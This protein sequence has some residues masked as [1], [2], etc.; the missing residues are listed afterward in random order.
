[1]DILIQAAQLLLSLSILVVLH[2]FGHF[3]PAKIFKT[4]VEKFYLFFDWKFSIF[5]KK[6]G[7]TEWGIGWLPLGGYVKISGMVDE[8][9]DTEQ[10]AQP[11]QPWEFRAKPAWQRLIIMLGGVT[12][13]LIL[14]CLIYILV[15]FTYGVEKMNPNDVTAGLSVTPMLEKYG[16]QTGDVVLKA[17][18]KVIDNAKDV[19]KE[20]MLRGARTF[21]VKHQDGKTEN[22]TLPEDIDYNLFKSGAMVP[23]NFRMKSNVVDSILPK[24]K[25][26]ANGIL[27]K[28]DIL[29]N[30]GSH[31]IEY[32][33]QTVSALYENKG[34]K[35]DITIARGND[36]L[37]KNIMVSKEGTIGFA[38]KDANY[39]LDTNKLQLVNYSFGQS[40]S[41]GTS[42]GIQTLKDYASQ[43]KYIF[44]K[45]GA[46][47]IGGFGAIG[48]LFPPTWDW[49][50]FWLNTALISIILAFMNILPIPALDGGHVVFLLYEIVTGKEAPQKVLEYAQ[51]VGFAILLTLM[52]Y[53][54]GNDIY[55]AIFGS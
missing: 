29:L 9:M 51:Y 28:G 36:T 53:A 4:R 26:N 34:K 13:N 1:M 50:I 3:I 38:P 20:I 43:L 21:V 37:V 40:I 32:F 24:S 12:V 39:D 33:D 2:E 49:Q 30:I 19:N 15:I 6:I 14:G 35:V 17:G 23:F 5:K 22:L 46:S 11:A 44:T 18:D 10:M 27:K 42:Y 41:E 52:V 31:D 55:K 45:K 47:S 7:E 25:S 8:S 16:F 48:K 54:N